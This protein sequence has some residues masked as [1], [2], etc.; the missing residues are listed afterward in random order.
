MLGTS[1]REFG[2]FLTIFMNEGRV[3][4]KLYL[5]EETLRTF[6]DATRIPHR[7]GG[8]YREPMARPSCYAPPGCVVA[9]CVRHALH[10]ARKPL[11]LRADRICGTAAQLF[12]GSGRRVVRAV[13]SC[14]PDE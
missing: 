3:D 5:S 13:W 2:R 1:P 8:W 12:D 6:L 10:T 7:D 4:G 14:C 9:I 11:H